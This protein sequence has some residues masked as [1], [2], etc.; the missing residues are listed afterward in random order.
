M[1]EIIF[2][3]SLKAKSVRALSANGGN[4][5]NTFNALVERMS[6]MSG[7]NI[8]NLYWFF[9]YSPIFA[10]SKNN[11]PSTTDIAVVRREILRYLKYAD[12][13]LWE[14]LTAPP[15]SHAEKMLNKAN[16]QAYPVICYKF[17]ECITLL[18]S[19]SC[20][21]SIR[22]L[23]EDALNKRFGGLKICGFEKY[24]CEYLLPYANE[25]GCLL[26]EYSLSMSQNDE[27]Y[28]ASITESYPGVWLGSKDISE[29]VNTEDKILNCDE[30]SIVASKNLSK[31]E[32]IEDKTAKEI[33]SST[34]MPD[35]A[36]ED[37][38]EEKITEAVIEIQEALIKLKSSVN[39]LKSKGFKKEFFE[40][41]FDF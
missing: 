38:S 36:A 3:Y 21:K 5:L 28:K 35:V 29:E 2:G 26:S 6:S 30:A 34:N 17:K 22:L 40:S 10:L 7:R 19:A 39:F 9:V 33:P 27:S 20:S 16:P 37:T 32:N 4:A 31:E 12:R 23:S 15:A 8:L 13:T 18:D 41:L 24:E 14:V 25:V 1:K 11:F